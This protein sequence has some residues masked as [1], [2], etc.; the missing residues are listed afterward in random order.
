MQH[1]PII[2]KIIALYE[3][4]REYISLRSFHKLIWTNCRVL[5]DDFP[6]VLYE[7][8][9]TYVVQM[10]VNFVK[11]DQTKYMDSKYFS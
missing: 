8:N 2:K 11:D 4:S 3:A 6:I 1:P 5:H 9:N 7:D 10:Q